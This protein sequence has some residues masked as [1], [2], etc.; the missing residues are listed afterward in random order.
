MKMTEAIEEARESG[1]WPVTG[2]EPTSVNV[3]FVSAGSE[4]DETQLDLYG[5]T[6]EK[7][8]EELEELWDSLCDEF[9]AAQDAVTG[10]E[11]LGYIAS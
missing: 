1:D 6:P 9:E 7:R 8:E 10:V 3:R 2:H 5:D 11:A 4:D